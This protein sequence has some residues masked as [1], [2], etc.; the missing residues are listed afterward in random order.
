MKGVNRVVIAV[1]DAERAASLFSQLLGA[2]FHDYGE[3]K[4][5]GARV[6]I[7]WDGGIEL[8]APISD[9]SDLARSIKEKG[10]GV[11]MVILN[12]GDVDEARVRAE[13]LGIRVTNTLEFKDPSVMDTPQHHFTRF[14]EVFLAPEDT[15][16]VHCLLAQIERESR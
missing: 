8:V 1:R 16:G 6:M 7:S 9:D 5:L 12:V 3:V 15:H 14:K 13:A 2:P 10:E 4:A 11:Q